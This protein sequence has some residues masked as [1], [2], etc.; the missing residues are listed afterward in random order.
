MAKKF[1][2]DEI[3]VGKFT[4][5]WGGNKNNTIPAAPDETNLL[6]YSGEAVQK[7]IKS[8]LQ[9]HENNKIGHIPPMTKDPDGFYHIRAF[10]NKNT[11]NE[12]IADPDENQALKLLDV[13]IP[14]SDEQGVMNI[15][16]LTTA[17]NQTNYVSIDG[18]VVLKMRFTSQTYNPVTG[19]YANTYEDGMM[20]IQRRSSASD[21]WRTIG[22]MAIKSVEADS[23]TYTDV[24]ISGLLNS[25]TCQL[26]IIVTGD[27]TQST[28]TYV[29]FQS[30][31]KTELK[32]TFRNEWQQPITGAA[33]S[34]LYTYTGAVAKTLNLKISGEGGVRSVQYAVGKVEYTE[35]PNQF[36]VTDTEGDSVKVMSHG[37]HEI[38]AWLS[39]D[40]T[41]VESEH[42]VSQ[43][44]VVSDPD[45]KTPYIMLN[46]IVKSLVNW[47]S[48]QFFQWAI[49]NPG[50]DVLPVTFKL[51]D[52]QEV[53][54]YLFYTEQQ[55]QNGV[56]YT[57]GNMI[58]IE[59]KETN[60]SAY[61]LFSTGEKYLRDRISFNVDNSQNFAP[62]DGADLIIN[63]KLRSNTETHPD[64]IINTVS[65]ENVPAT[66][67]NFGFISDGWVEDNNG[68]KCL[69]VP[70]GRNIT[71]DYET[72]SDF[73]Q[74]QKTGSL[75]FEIDF[76]TR[77]I[78][79]EDE[80][81]LRMCSY[82]K[83]NNPLGWEMKA[84]EAC[85][86]TLAKV[87]R[88]NQDIGYRE[89]T[90]TKVAV[91]LLYNLSST[92]QNYCRIFVNG[93]INREINYATDDTFVQY[94]E[95]KQTSQ[96]I[97]IGSSGADIDIYSIKVYKKALTANDVRQ[98]YMA[99]L[100]NS[101]EKIAFRDS[102]SILNGNTISYDLVYEKYNVILW[103]GKYA[104]YGNTK[105]DKFNGTLIIHIPG[106]PENSGTLY[107]M[108]EKGQGT[109]SMLYFWWNGQWGFNEDGYWVD[110]NGVNRG[111]CYQLTNDVPGALKLVG[112][113]NFASSAQSHKINT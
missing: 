29:V 79:N 1:R 108:N 39:V 24:D 30:V 84:T 13:T 3:P 72:F 73:I 19:K 109:S 68:I 90:R 25:G 26:R 96:G 81:V 112:K 74:T 70:S 51:T 17:S 7:F 6:P 87:T 111:K 12:W 22:T 88:K 37:V 46:Q 47:T 107:D 57:F 78:T 16:E 89:G 102:N 83:D 52:I 35:T 77:N 58:E 99:S 2:T 10:A 97:R 11:Y 71:I 33:M 93:I 34:L 54:N 86:M 61:M 60:F 20:T 82:T 106:K 53:E 4:E 14:I 8:Y 80:P 48:V 66:F 92:G 105:K 41:D 113:V 45:N 110:E 59:S 103:K 94:V 67:E 100:D 42:I 65:G 95:G 18:S 56:V 43:V 28:T 9:D 91:N 55:A 32:L 69:R 98:N 36:D 49:Y 38:E 31:T 62:T 64:T 15:V 101:E 104:T 27:Q 76:A 23:D 21:S 63:P 5:D 40:G 75:T 85:F 50:S 44:M